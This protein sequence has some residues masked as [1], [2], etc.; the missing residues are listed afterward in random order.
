MD[1]ERH[2]FLDYSSIT[3]PLAIAGGIALLLLVFAYC[4]RLFRRG[5]F[6]S[7][8]ERGV[9]RHAP[10]T[11]RSGEPRITIHPRNRS[12]RDVEGLI[13]HQF[14]PW[15]LQRGFNTNREQTLPSNRANYNSTQVTS[16]LGKILILLA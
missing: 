4:F 7:D 3:V 2:N 14:L 8:S 11:Q 10:T 16:S 15:S 12:R 13:G 6:C 5:V 1:D 9:L